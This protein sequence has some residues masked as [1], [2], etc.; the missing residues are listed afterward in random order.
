MID[1]AP[2]AED[3]SNRFLEQIALAIQLKTLRAS[4]KAATR[5]SQ[6][7]FPILHSKRKGTEKFHDGGAFEAVSLWT[8]ANSAESHVSDS[9]L[10]HL[11]GALRPSVQ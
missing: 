5:H 3:G 1:E 11:V 7:G 10:P 9:N 6:D 8:Q 4:L 2:Q